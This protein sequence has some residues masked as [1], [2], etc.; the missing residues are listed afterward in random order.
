MA[1]L[2][3]L[4]AALVFGAN[5]AE[6]RAPAVLILHSNQRPTPSQI[7]IEDTLRAVVPDGVRHPVRI[8]SEYLDDEWTSL[9]TYGVSQADVLRDKYGGRNVQ[10]IVVDALP[11]LLFVRQ[12]RE[13]I[14]P[15]VPIVHVAV[16]RDRVDAAAL[17]KD[18]VGDF[19][20]ND[21]APTLQLA[22]RLHP[23]TTRLV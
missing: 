19:E 16:A 1:A 21:P 5:A 17:P 14:F 10:V 13:R 20:D 3:G 15:A 18:I 11:A 4:V 2:A 7:V 12:F 8:Y 23:D 6:L 22:L 9:Q